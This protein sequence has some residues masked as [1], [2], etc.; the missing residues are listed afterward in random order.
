MFTLFPLMRFYAPLLILFNSSCWLIEVVLLLF[1]YSNSNCNKFIHVSLSSL[2]CSF[3]FFLWFSFWYFLLY[4]CYFYYLIFSFFYFKLILAFFRDL[5]ISRN[6]YFCIIYP[7]ATC[8][9]NLTKL[10][11]TINLYFALFSTRYNIEQSL[12]SVWS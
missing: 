2:N 6:F 7:I 8:V 11:S 5:F 10:K 12:N 3:L 4:L 9:T 1:L